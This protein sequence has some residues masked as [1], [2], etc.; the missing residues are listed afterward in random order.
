[1]P[2]GSLLIL[3]ATLAASTASAQYEEEEVSPEL[4]GSSRFSLQTGWRYT[5]NTRFYNDYYSRAVNRGLPRAGGAIGGPLLT[6]T[7]AY[8]I[9]NLIELGIDLFATYERMQLTRQPGLNAITYGALMG[10]RFQKRLE[11]G[12]E[13]LI[14]SVG[15]LTGPLLAA[16]YFDGGRSVEN[17]TQAFGASLGATL[18]LNDKWGLCFEY[19]FVFAKGEAENVG[20]YD[21]A[22][23]WLSVGMTYQFPSARYRPM[24]RNF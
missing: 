16:S 1:M 22:G 4:E 18:R 11:I 23:N 6:A 12:P 13:G 5:P 21:A 15:I 7:F 10:L 9:T 8:S 24:S 2:R 14:P 20:P 3:L 19:R 17:F